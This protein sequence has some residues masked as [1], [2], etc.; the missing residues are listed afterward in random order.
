MALATMSRGGRKGKEIRKGKRLLMSSSTFQIIP[1][2]PDYI[3]SEEAQRRAAERVRE[4]AANSETVTT[5]TS[6]D[7]K[8]LHPVEDWAGV[9]CPLCSRDV[10][11][12]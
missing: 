9:E 5:W 7:P 1:I 3:P 2:D 10:S 12:W 4:V 6:D 11:D 8:I